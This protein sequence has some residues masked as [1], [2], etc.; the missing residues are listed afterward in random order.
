M[1][2]KAEAATMK[3]AGM[4][5]DEIAAEL[6]VEP[7]TI[8]DWLLSQDT[9]RQ[10]RNHRNDCIVEAYQAGRTIAT[11][12]DTFGVTQGTVYRI[13]HRKKI[14]LRRDREPLSRQERRTMGSARIW[15]RAGSQ[16]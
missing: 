9:I 16:R 3:E 6:S 11:I 2:D 8:Y 5:I 13:L 4:S 15:R 10:A 14:T 1:E 7:A 12:C